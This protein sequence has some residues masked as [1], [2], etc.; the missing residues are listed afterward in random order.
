MT[1]YQHRSCR[2][3]GKRI[4]RWTNGKQTPASKQFCDSRCSRNHRQSTGPKSP[5]KAPTTQVAECT[6]NDKKRP[7][8]RALL[9]PVSATDRRSE[10][11]LCKACGRSISKPLEYCNDRCRDY[12]PLPPRKP[13]GDWFI[14][15]GPMDYCFDCGLG[16]TPKKPSG[17]ITPWR[18]RDGKLR[19][20]IR[21]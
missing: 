17:F 1:D 18:G 15:A 21:R 2:F 12:V 16:I 4:P 3:C 10:Y 14:I 13:D 19:C 20:E 7:I 9:E 11:G 8:L 6:E 5:K